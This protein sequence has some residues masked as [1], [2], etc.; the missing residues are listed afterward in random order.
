[1]KQTV[2]VLVALILIGGISCSWQEMPQREGETPSP[3]DPPYSIPP[4]PPHPIFLWGITSWVYEVIDERLENGTHGTITRCEYRDGIGY[5][6]EPLG[7]SIELGYSF[8]T[9]DGTVL[10]EN[11]ENPIE[12]TYPELN[13]KRKFLALGI[14]PS[15]EQEET[16]N[17]FQC[18]AIYPFT[19]PRVKAFFYRD[20]FPLC[21]TV[22]AITSYKDGVCF[23][24]GEHLL[25]TQPYWEF[26]DCNGNLLCTGRQGRLCPELNIDFQNLKIII[27]TL[28]F[29]SN[30]Y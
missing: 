1:M 18:Y 23:L 2:L 6:F 9:C 8:R 25:S 7:N 30:H 28:P 15:W 10:Y 26:F 29:I 27:E 21:R 22:V 16:F 5:L 17:D 13:I 20:P 12:D 19:L 24:L 4:Y 11:E 3:C 14:Y